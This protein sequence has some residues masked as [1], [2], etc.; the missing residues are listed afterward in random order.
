MGAHLRWSWCCWGSSPGPF[1][2]G[3]LFGVSPAQGLLCASPMLINGLL[4]SAAHR[5]RH[6][7]TWGWLWLLGVSL[8]FFLNA[9]MAM[10]HLQGASVFASFLFLFTTAFR[11]AAAA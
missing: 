8:R 6:I 4:F 1:D 11:R 3:D 7:E 10:S 9:M 5:R 2:A